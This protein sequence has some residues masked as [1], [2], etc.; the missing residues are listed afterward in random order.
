MR[1]PAVI[2]AA[3]IALVLLVLYVIS[4]SPPSPPGPPG[5]PGHESRDERQE[6]GLADAASLGEADAETRAVPLLRG[7]VVDSEGR[8]GVGGVEV[9]LVHFDRASLPIATATTAGDG[10]FRLAGV[11][12]P[13]S[14]FTVLAS[15]GERTAAPFSLAGTELGDEAYARLVL[16]LA[17]TV[18][19]RA[20]DPGGG[21][22]P[23]AEIC[24]LSIGDARKGSR[25]AENVVRSITAGP[26]GAFEFVIRAGRLRLWSRS[27]GGAFGGRADVE[28]TLVD[29]VH[30][31]DVMTGGR[32][33]TRRLRV[34]D[35]DGDPLG[36]AVVVVGP[37]EKAM[38]LVDDV[39]RDGIADFKA[40]EDGRLDLRIAR[41]EEPLTLGIGAVGFYPVHVFVERRSP[42][43]E[44]RVVLERRPS[45]RVRLTSVSG[46]EVFRLPIEIEVRPEP[47][48][49]RRAAV[50]G[51]RRFG[52]HLDHR[53]V[54]EGG[55]A[56]GEVVKWI[57]GA[58]PRRLADDLW[59]LTLAGPGE[60]ELIVKVPGTPWI[61]QELSIDEEGRPREVEVAVPA[62]RLVR[63][64]AE[65]PGSS[66]PGEPAMERPAT[67][68]EIGWFALW[69][70]DPEDLP[71]EP[72]GPDSS[73]FN[74]VKWLTGKNSLAPDPELGVA[75]ALLWLRT[76]VRSVLYGAASFEAGAAGEIVSIT[77]PD[78]PPPEGLRLPW[79]TIWADPSWPTVRFIVVDG[80]DRVE[81]PALKLQ[82]DGDAPQTV[83]PG[84]SFPVKSRRWIQ[85]DA[86]GVARTTLSPGVYELAL[87]RSLEVRT[88]RTVTIPAGVPEL[89]FEV[90]ID[91]LELRRVE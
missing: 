68:E 72:P 9:L 50:V 39:P 26:D 76:G 82:L 65:P 1:L 73:A 24:V 37:N 55:T 25:E 74:R 45:I 77:V 64:V 53:Y 79:P 7:R 87:D 35:G 34:V 23:G 60:N 28:A 4:A 30:A 11:L 51:E 33:V 42:D 54:P 43:R 41:S 57:S 15:D 22:V 27:P 3:L 66:A 61:R 89:A 44:C 90:D 8:G 78:D 10:R 13:G 5:E 29:V 49:V 69:V 12:P 6:E 84:T 47:A 56:L 17:A 52:V 85:T 75:T 19:G 48:T 62:G 36:G 18:R 88:P 81:V 91:G 46:P 58:A 21:V 20:V 80:G 32:G 67:M 16:R 59:E 38:R 86:T 40:N 2:S 31:G 70:E 71:G 83:G 63:F 14:T